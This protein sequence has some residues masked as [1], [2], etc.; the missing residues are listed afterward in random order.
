MLELGEQSD[1]L[2]HQ[3]GENIPTDLDLLITVGKLSRQIAKGAKKRISRIISCNS[4][5]EV[6]PI[7]DRYLS[8]GDIILIKGSRGLKLE[9]I[10]EEL[11]NRE[12]KE[13]KI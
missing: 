12:P 9:Q 1:R 11:R 8:D 5:K 2:H 4:A 7:I 3:I 10:V 13:L 6:V